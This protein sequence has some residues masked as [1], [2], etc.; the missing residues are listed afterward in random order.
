MQP[1][2]AAGGA[3]MQRPRLPAPQSSCG[4]CR[5]ALVLLLVALVWAH[6]RYGGGGAVDELD[7]PVWAVPGSRLTG[8]L[9]SPTLLPGGGCMKEPKYGPPMTLR[10]CGAGERPRIVYG[11]VL[12]SRL[13][14]RVMRVGPT[15]KPGKA[16]VLQHHLA[17]KLGQSVGEPVVWLYL[18]GHARTLLL[19]APKLRSFLAQSTPNWYVAISVWDEL[20]TTSDTWWGNKNGGLHANPPLSEMLADVVCAFDGRAIV[21]SVHRGAKAPGAADSAGNGGQELLWPRVHSLAAEGAK[22]M[23][24]PLSNHDIV[25]KSRPDLLLPYAIDA[26][27]LSRFLRRQPRFVFMLLHESGAAPRGNDVN[28]VLWITSVLGYSQQAEHY[29]AAKKYLGPHKGYVMYEEFIIGSSIPG[30][31]GWAAQQKVAAQTKVEYRSRPPL[32]SAFLR[33]D[34]T[35]FFNRLG[36][37]VPSTDPCFNRST[38]WV[39]G[40]ALDMATI[41]PEGVATTAI[42]RGPFVACPIDLAEPVRPWRMDITKGYMCVRDRRAGPES[43]KT[44]DAMG[45][46]L[47]WWQKS[48]EGVPESAPMNADGWSRPTGWGVSYRLDPVAAGERERP[49]VYDRA[50]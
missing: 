9:R 30:S 48:F 29:A 8:V 46:P 16:A 32:R 14:S 26:P 2:T 47:A 21:E 31:G 18:A 37:G 4:G 6:G 34:F 39:D 45:V 43:Q 49:C 42:P 36:G 13:V 38:C 1:L 15:A 40:A 44:A 3:P 41:N 28:E 5:A 20:E 27:S 35:V 19:N 23:G 7:R 22:I 10:T 50:R 25:I 12:E 33:Y 11:S 24:V 17:N